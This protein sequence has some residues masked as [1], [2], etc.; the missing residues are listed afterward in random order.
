[1]RPKSRPSIPARLERQEDEQVNGPAPAEQLWRKQMRKLVAVTFLTLD[2]VMQAPGGADEDH[3][4]G[5]AHGGWV[6]PY[7]DEQG[8][9][10]MVEL[11]RRAGA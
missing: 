1:V 7:F 9:A 11:I 10:H 5:F 3:E 2:G 8:G 6:V 4:G